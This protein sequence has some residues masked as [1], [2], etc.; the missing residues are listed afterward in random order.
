MFLT[1]HNQAMKYTIPA[2]VNYSIGNKA[3]I[4]IYAVS[5][6]NGTVNPMS[7]IKHSIEYADSEADDGALTL[8]NNAVTAFG[9]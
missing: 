3:V 4:I 8:P 9:Q 5:E 7:L 6:C 2:S 1:P